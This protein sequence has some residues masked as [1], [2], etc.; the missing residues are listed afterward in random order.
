[1]Y[2]DRVLMAANRRARQYTSKISALSLA[3]HG[4]L[5]F[6]CPTKWANNKYYMDYVHFLEEQKTAH[7]YVRKFQERFGNS[8]E[9]DGYLSDYNKSLYSKGNFSALFVFALSCGNSSPFITLS[10]R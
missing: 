6:L 8:K 3:A 9:T 2:L 1:M 10:L 5:L 4:E 7:L